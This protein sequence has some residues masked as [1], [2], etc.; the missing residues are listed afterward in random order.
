MLYP[1]QAMLSVIMPHMKHASS[2]AIAVLATLCFLYLLLLYFY[3]YAILQK[4]RTVLQGGV[5]LHSLEW[6]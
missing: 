5:G 6:R 1:R 3:R 2:L 4:G